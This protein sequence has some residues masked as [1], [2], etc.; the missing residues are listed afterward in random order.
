MSSIELEEPAESQMLG[1]LSNSED[2]FV[3]DLEKNEEE[4]SFRNAG[5]MIY[6][7]QDLMLSQQIGSDQTRV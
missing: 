1:S 4:K 6:K 7:N 2:T 5:D 3:A